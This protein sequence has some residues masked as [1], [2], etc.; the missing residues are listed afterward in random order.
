M[1]FL[2]T[3]IFAQFIAKGWPLCLK[4]FN[5][6]GESE[7]LLILVIDE[8]SFLYFTLMKT[9]H[10]EKIN[11]FYYFRKNLF[12]FWNKQILVFFWIQESIRKPLTGHPMLKK[13]YNLYKI[14]W[15]KKSTLIAII[16]L[17]MG[18]KLLWKNKSFILS[19]DLETFDY[20]LGEK[21]SNLK[22][23][24]EKRMLIKF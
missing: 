19:L 5:L 4:I 18:N 13:D 1:D 7:D 3:L 20:K 8:L 9:N 2:K 11:C 17:M 23:K 10:F 21:F 22:C 16:I 6:Q 24:T 15:E 14:Y 12:I